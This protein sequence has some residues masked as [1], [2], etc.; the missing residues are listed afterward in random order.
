[1]ETPV[2]DA[3]TK[4]P[5]LPPQPLFERLP[6]ST[7]L[8][9]PPGFEAKCRLLMLPLGV[10]PRFTPEMTL[11]TPE[12]TAPLIRIVRVAEVELKSNEY[13]GHGHPELPP[14]HS[15]NVR[16]PI[17]SAR[18]APP[19]ARTATRASNAY[20]IV[21]AN[22]HTPVLSSYSP[23]LNGRVFDHSQLAGI[24]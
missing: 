8:H 6:V 21:R 16:L 4:A 2:P 24:L 14:P 5:L 7:V 3:Q 11:F 17:W 19:K 20:F 10:N 18:A 9:P 1:M 22:K 15:V 13:V 12:V 23:H